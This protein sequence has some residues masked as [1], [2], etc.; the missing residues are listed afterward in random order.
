MSQPLA[1]GRGGWLSAAVPGVVLVAGLGCVLGG[2]A[3]T[4]DWPVVGTF[5]GA[6]EGGFVG[7][8]AGLVLAVT[9]PPLGRATRSRWAARLT[10][11]LV[12]AAVGLGV[13]GLGSGAD[14]A[15]DPLAVVLLA[16]WILVAGA[17]GPAIAFGVRP[18]P[19]GR[20]GFTWA[21]GVWSVCL[22]WGCG[23]GAGAGAVTGLVIG[24]HYL[25]TAVAAAIEGAVLGSVSGLVLA[26]L[27]TGIAVLPRLHPLP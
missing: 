4:A 10:S 25:P 6:V 20:P 19:D 1:A 12:A 27:A 14:A 3:G 22:A 11:G 13:A 18:M 7:A 16:A 24:L 8:V 5:F 2:A 15:R 21:A 26:C 17:L 9:L 23:L